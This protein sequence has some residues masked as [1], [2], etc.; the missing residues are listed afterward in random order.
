MFKKILMSVGVLVLAA[1]TAQAVEDGLGTNVLRNI[2]VQTNGVIDL[3]GTAITN[4]NQ[5]GSTADV[6]NLQ[7]ATNALNTSVTNV[8]YQVTN[9]LYG[10]TNALNTSVTNLSYQVTNV[11]YNATNVLNTATGALNT[12]VVNL[13]ARTNYWNNGV[14]IY[15]GAAQADGVFA[16][17]LYFMG[18]GSV[19]S[20]ACATNSTHAGR[21]LGLALGTDPA[22]DGFLLNGQC[23]GAWNF[24][25]GQILY[26][27][28][29]NNQITATRPTGSNHFVRIVGYAI[30][31]TNIYFNPDRTYIELIGE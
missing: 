24:A 10:A 17:N 20:N 14:I 31:I 21:L 5:V 1:L 2:R 12:A 7:G 18:D 22:V 6:A 15:Q 30:N 4:W 19:W 11:L 9:V 29:N 28:T 27:A 3:G 25:A 13:N 26:M 16:T 8:S 23:T